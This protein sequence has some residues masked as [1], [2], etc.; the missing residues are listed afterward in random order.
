[1]KV[2]F[3]SNASWNLY[4]FREGFMKA[5]KRA[6][7]RVYF[8]A[9]FDGCSDKLKEKGYDFIRISL[10]RKGTNFFNDLTLMVR[11]FSIYRKIKPDIV[12][13]YTIKPNIYGSIAAKFSGTKCVNTVTG[14][15]YI[16]IQKNI[17]IFPV[18]ILYWLACTFAEKTIFHNKEDLKVFLDKG[19]IDIKK[20]CVVN[21]SG[22]NTEFFAPGTS[23]PAYPGN[24]FKFLFIGRL[25]RDKGIF[26]LIEAIRLVKKEFSSASL[27]LLGK[28][29][30]SNPAAVSGIKIKEWSETGLIKY[31]EETQDV[32]PFIKECDCVV[33]PSY[34]EGLPRT[35]L[36][37]L[38]ME[39]PIIAT[40]VPGCRE[41]IKDGINGFSIPAKN[42]FALAEAM[43]KMIMS[44]EEKRKEMGRA[45]RQQ[46][47]KDFN[48]KE[49]IE[50]YQQIFLAAMQRKSEHLSLK[51]R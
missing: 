3:V 2:I 38:S 35:L 51:A 46:V 42:P 34:R 48:E 4:N 37:A 47:V 30:D 29:D 9:P 1:M 39:K 5:L 13:H 22:V 21:G 7:H 24:G 10:E 6:G 16:F 43:K 26:E 50:S 31:F 17:Y 11:L 27:L 28:S 14:L 32:R 44:T 33:L 12:F 20:S 18:R 19:L 49:V 15:G 41:I 45:G 23:N 36:E 8:C 25:L 40:A